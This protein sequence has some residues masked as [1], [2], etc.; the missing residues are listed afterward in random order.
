M[1]SLKCVRSDF[2]SPRLLLL[3]CQV[4]G[5]FFFEYEPEEWSFRIEEQVIVLLLPFSI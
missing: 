1:H 2:P 3:F 5:H 4:T